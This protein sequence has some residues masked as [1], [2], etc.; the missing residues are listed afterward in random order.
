MCFTSNR[1]TMNNIIYNPFY[2]IGMQYAGD[3]GGGISGNFID[4]NVSTLQEF[5]DAAALGSSA[6]VRIHFT[7]DIALTTD[8]TLNTDNLQIYGHDHKLNLE[9]HTLKIIGQT[10]YFYQ[11]RF[12]ANST[13]SASS[14]SNYSSANIQL[15]STANSNRFFF[16]YCLFMNFV[17]KDTDSARNI[18]NVKN[19]S[20]SYP[21]AHLYFMFCECMTNYVNSNINTCTFCINHNGSYHALTVHQIDYWGNDKEANSTNNFAI[22]GNSLNGAAKLGWIC[23]GSCTY[24]KTVTGVLLPN[25]TNIYNPSMQQFEDV[26]NRFVIHFASQLAADAQNPNFKP[27]KCI[28]L[29]DN[30]TLSLSGDIDVNYKCEFRYDAENA[31]LNI[32]GNK[33]I[34]F[35]NSTEFIYLIIKGRVKLNFS[36]PATFQNCLFDIEFSGSTVY[37]QFYVYTTVIFNN[38]NFETLSSGNQNKNIVINCIDGLLKLFNTNTAPAQ[39][40]YLNN[41]RVTGSESTI[42]ADKSINITSELDNN[43]NNILFDSAIN[44]NSKNIVPN[45]VIALAF[46]NVNNTLTPISTFINNFQNIIES[47]FPFGSVAE[48]GGQIYIY[49]LL[50]STIVFFKFYVSTFIGYSG[51]IPAKTLLY[52]FNIEIQDVRFIGMS[53]NNVYHFYISDKK[54]Y[55]LEVIP[56]AE[57]VDASCTSII[58]NS[59]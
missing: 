25:M 37:I 58:L 55:N 30:Q 32:I 5:T 2:K 17:C 50:N 9:N 28:Y 41:I 18:I 20:G 14:A 48:Y 33:S 47:E 44:E 52:T 26:A 15:E 38:C 53:D 31:E 42:I 46:K 6:S 43:D 12:N 13:V 1:I 23:D 10:C 29:C 16:E 39:N 27:Q 8:L 57:Y 56:N 36:E 45:S 19:I 59:N 22:V 24:N 35:M 34:T 11:L 4:A 3:G 51:D 21:S 49:K 54:L 7:Q 40:Y